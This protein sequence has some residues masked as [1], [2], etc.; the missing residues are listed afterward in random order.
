M[1]DS[2]NNRLTKRFKQTII[3]KQQSQFTGK[4]LRKIR[5]ICSDPEATD[6]SSDESDDVITTNRK[7]R[8][9]R[10]IVCEIVISDPNPVDDVISNKDD[11]MTCKDDVIMEE[12]NKHKEISIV[13]LDRTSEC[14]FADLTPWGCLRLLICFLFGIF[15]PLKVAVDTLSLQ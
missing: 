8:S 6:S 4:N 14:Y 12:N 11:V 9:P 13:D 3:N 1:S 2:H 10:R 15:L 7:P 5:V